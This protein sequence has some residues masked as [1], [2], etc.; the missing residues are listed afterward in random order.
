MI[1]REQLEFRRLRPPSQ[2][3]SGKPVRTLGGDPVV[4]APPQSFRRSRRVMRRRFSWR[5]VPLL[6]LCEHRGLA[7]TNGPSLVSSGGAHGVQPFAGS[8]PPTVGRSFLSVPTHMPLH[9]AARPD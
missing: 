5:G 3:R 8:F 2:V 4:Q 1:E 9:R 7:G 6:D